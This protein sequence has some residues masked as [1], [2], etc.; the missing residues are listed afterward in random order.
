MRRQ[1]S[2]AVRVQAPSRGVVSRLPG[3]SAD[4]MPAQGGIAPGTQKRAAS[5]ASNV[6]YEDGVTCNAPGYEKVKLEAS[7]LSGLVAQWGL[8]ERAGS[9]EDRSGNGHTLQDVP[10]ILTPAGAEQGV[11][12]EG[13]RFSLAAR[14]ASV[15]QV[16]AA[17]DALSLDAQFSSGALVLSA[18]GLSDSMSLD[19]SLASAARA[20][21]Y[22]P[23]VTSYPTI[24][25]SVRSGNLAP[26]SAMTFD[27]TRRELWALHAGT[28]ASNGIYSMHRLSTDTNAY[29]AEYK[30]TNYPQLPFG[31][32]V[33]LYDPIH[34]LVVF[35]GQAFAYE[36]FNPATGVFGFAG[37]GPLDGI[38]QS[39][40][41]VAMD[42]ARGHTLRLGINTNKFEVGYVSGTAYTNLYSTS[43]AVSGADFKAVC[44][45]DGADKFVVLRASGSPAITYIDPVTYAATNSTTGVSASSTAGTYIFALQG[46][47]YVAFIT[48]GGSL[49]II[50][51]S[52]DTVLNTSVAMATL[53]SA[54]YNFCNSKLY[55]STI[56]T[57]VSTVSLDDFTKTLVSPDYCYALAFDPFGGRV[58]GCTTDT[59]PNRIITV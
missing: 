27:P 59:A 18:P 55:C 9:R 49:A 1:N 25:Y 31:R 6:R 37:Y 28:G 45:S 11:D 53:N 24:S 46:T 47:P 44:Y 48:S 34:D 54:V 57:G 17:Q 38:G 12:A 3:E 30:D 2:L 43:S 21:A 16:G 51:A 26:G 35:V 52:N 23:V 36:Y 40:N 14:F 32:G 13:G 58:Y 42:T 56:T 33:P 41:R 39:G 7:V 10:G 5:R 20:F 50:D 29:L 4:R 15:G 19:A 8:D 22:C